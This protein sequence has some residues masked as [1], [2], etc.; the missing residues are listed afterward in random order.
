MEHLGRLELAL[1]LAGD[2]PHDGLEHPHQPLV[3]HHLLVGVRVAV[4]DPVGVE[5]V[6]QPTGLV[7]FSV[8]TGQAQQSA[9]VVARVDDL[10]LDAHRRAVLVGLDR[11]FLDI[12]AEM[13]EAFD[14]F[15]DAP[16]LTAGERLGAGELLPQQPVGRDD[17]VAHVDRV[18][19]VGDAAAG[20]E[21]HQLAG[22]VHPGDFQIV[23]ALAV[24]QAAGVELPGFGVDEV[25]GE[26]S[27]VTA[28]ERVRQRHVAP[29]QADHV[30]S[31]EQQGQRV[32]QAGG[33]V[34]PQGLGVQRPIGQRELEVPGHQ[35]RVERVAVFVGAV[36]DH[37]KRFDAGDFQALQGAE[38]VV[39]ALGHL[40]GGLLDGDNPAA[41]VREPH[42]VAGEALGKRGD[43]LVRPRIQR[44]VPGQIE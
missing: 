34:W 12:E 16:A 26:G 8:E 32:D 14:A 39:L 33:G 4:G 27:G 3:R 2:G 31:H 7:L 20:L 43:V 13:V 36:G 5:V 19:L 9:L 23:L 44:H 15:G 35:H 17:A 42:E 28:E 10:G 41:Q 30:H 21:V 38:H 1:E 6:Q 24:G 40:A 22:D 29:E 11:E 18:E 25:R 37:G